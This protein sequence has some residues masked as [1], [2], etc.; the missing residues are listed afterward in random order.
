MNPWVRACILL[1]V[2]HA[3]GLVR[4]KTLKFGDCLQKSLQDDDISKGDGRWD[5]NILGRRVRNIAKMRWT[6][7]H[8]YQVSGDSLRVV[9]AGLQE[10]LLL[11]EKVCLNGFLD[12]DLDLDLVGILVLVGFCC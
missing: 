5:W 3:L 4:G 7:R 2:A 9:K 8:E 6:C 10:A 1:L 12:L 11:A